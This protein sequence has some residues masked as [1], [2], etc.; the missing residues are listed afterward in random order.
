M[1]RTACLIFPPSFAV[2]EASMGPRQALA[3]VAALALAAP[4]VAQAPEIRPGLWEF[5]MSAAKG[6]TQKICFTPAMVKDMKGVAAKG[7]PSSDCKT[8][9]EKVSGGTRNFHVSCTRPSKYEADV[10]L[11]VHGPDHFSMTQD[12]V[13]EHAGKKSAGKMSF[14]YRRVGDCPK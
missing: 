10:A 14:V 13:T 6:M 8:S 7:D 1:A 4:A 9:K 2:P 3:A 11:T 5:S 12:F